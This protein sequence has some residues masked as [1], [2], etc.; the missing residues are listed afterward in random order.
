MATRVQV[1]IDCSDPRRL[2]EFWTAALHYE[3]EFPTGDEDERR[4]LAEHPELEGM[5]AAAID[6]DWIGPR[7]YFQKV[8]EPKSSKNRVH[9]D[10]NVADLEAE[11]DRL[12]GLGATVI[13][14]PE[15]DDVGETWAVLTDPEGNEFCVQPGREFVQ[16]S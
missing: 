12:V 13:R 9:L 8:P 6:P 16:R 15:T 7:L 10:L 1:V 11:I 5:A 4:F 3:R 2:V 14:G